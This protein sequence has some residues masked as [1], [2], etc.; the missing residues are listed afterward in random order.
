M[1]KKWLLSKKMKKNK[2]GDIFQIIK[3]YEDSYTLKFSFNYQNYC[4]FIWGEDRKVELKI[5]EHEQKFGLGSFIVLNSKM[6]Q[7]TNECI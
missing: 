5:T 2:T 6:C 3:S 4:I 7:N 1:I